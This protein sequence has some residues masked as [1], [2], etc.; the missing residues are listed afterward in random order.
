[1]ATTSF[2]TPAIWVPYCLQTEQS[3][4]G[5]TRRDH[6]SKDENNSNS[7]WKAYAKRIGF[8]R[9][10]STLGKSMAEKRALKAALSANNGSG[11]RP[12]FH[13]NLSVHRPFVVDFQSAI[14][15][16]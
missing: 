7:N 1:M 14:L 16:V 3:S 12:C 5:L 15:A 2:Q 10:G 6:C 13:D 4:I 9:D 8:F 11:R